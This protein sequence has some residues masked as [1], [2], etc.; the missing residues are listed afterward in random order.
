MLREVRSTLFQLGDSDGMVRAARLDY[1]L[2]SADRPGDDEDRAR[3]LRHLAHTLK[4]AQRYDEALAKLGEA[5]Q[6]YEA[7]AKTLPGIQAGGVGTL[8]DLAMNLLDLGDAA[9]GRRAQ[10]LASV[11]FAAA[12][13]VGKVTALARLREL[14]TVAI[15]QE[16]RDGSGARR[17]AEETLAAL[18]LAPNAELGQAIGEV[19]ATGDRLLLFWND[20]PASRLVNERRLAVRQSLPGQAAMLLARDRVALARTLPGSERQRQDRLIQEARSACQREPDTHDEPLLEALQELAWAFVERGD[21]RS[22]AAVLD[23]ALISSKKAAPSRQPGQHHLGTLADLH[24]RAGDPV[25]EMSV[26][27]Y[28]LALARQA[29]APRHEE[30]VESMAA[31]C[32]PL[33]R[34]GRD[35]D[36]LE[37]ARRALATEESA[38]SC[39]AAEPHHLM[40]LAQQLRA[41]GEKDR[42]RKVHEKALAILEPEKGGWRTLHARHEAALALLLLEQ[43][44]RERARALATDALSQR[45]A[46]TAARQTAWDWGEEDLAV[47]HAALGDLATARELCEA[48]VAREGRHAGVPPLELAATLESLARAERSAGARPLAEA[49][50]KRALAVREANRTRVR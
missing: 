36:A 28:R 37:M 23:R 19:A 25:G 8:E 44:D 47:V 20:R 7:V 48:A 1:T 30:L 24:R 22:A 39:S 13:K 42:A 5:L 16:S 32:G 29:P 17:L 18:D 33:R 46:E 38:G 12:H 31:L 3:R 21:G 35:R 27:E 9:A 10:Q 15:L 4:L 43:N 45:R 14:S 50:E 34:L 40:A 49:H 41:V 2:S 11:S 26:L 6:V